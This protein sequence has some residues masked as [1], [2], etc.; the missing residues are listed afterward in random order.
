MKDIYK[1]ALIFIFILLIVSASGLI[2]Y[3]H[4]DNSAKNYE[5]SVFQEKGYWLYEIKQN[6]K[7][8]IRQ[9]YVPALNGKKRFK[10]KNDALTIGNIA[11]QKLNSHNL[12]TIYRDDIIKN[13]IKYIEVQ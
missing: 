5:L 7:P 8:F 10:T 3:S 6:N 2:F 12:P 1:Y 11:L 4:Q 9:E 13:N